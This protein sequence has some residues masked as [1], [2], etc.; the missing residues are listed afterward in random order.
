[1]T[2]ERESSSRRLSKMRSYNLQTWAPPVTPTTSP[3]QWHWWPHRWTTTG[4][5]T[6]EPITWH[7]PAHPV[8]ATTISSTICRPL[9]PTSLSPL[10]LPLDGIAH[11]VVVAELTWTKTLRHSTLE[12][13]Q[14]LTMFTPTW[15]VSIVRPGHP[16]AIARAPI[17]NL[18]VSSHWPVEMIQPFTVFWVLVKSSVATSS[19][20]TFTNGEPQ[21]PFQLVTKL[22]HLNWAFQHLTLSSRS[23]MTVVWQLSLESPQLLVNGLCL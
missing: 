21:T 23:V 7:P 19:I 22:L 12:D 14:E 4:Q 13:G 17:L 5:S 15:L 9:T 1:M 6:W 3:S 10:C 20:P 18:E 16:L 11:R 8:L 2:A